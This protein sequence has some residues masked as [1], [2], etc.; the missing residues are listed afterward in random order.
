[1]G[2][3]EGVKWQTS[4]AA[5]NGPKQQCPL[6][7]FEALFLGKR[8][9]DS[10]DPRPSLPDEVFVKEEVL[11]LAGAVLFFAFQLSGNFLYP[12][13][14]SPIEQSQKSQKAPNHPS[15]ILSG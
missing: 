8:D 13:K 10:L 6:E 15:I 11:E 7:A 2:I 12:M 5:Y 9:K 4:R 1:M 14:S 3:L